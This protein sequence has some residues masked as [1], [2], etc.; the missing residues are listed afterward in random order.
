MK[1]IAKGEIV[2]KEIVEAT[3]TE[4]HPNFHLRARS[5]SLFEDQIKSVVETDGGID[6]A[7]KNKRTVKRLKGI[8][9]D[10]LEDLRDTGL[11]KNQRKVLDGWLNKLKNPAF[12]AGDFAEIINQTCYLKFDLSDEG[13]EKS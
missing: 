4:P 2:S 11:S 6:K 9:V 3:Q 13:V 1:S 12:G 7:F 10:V 8:M 5:V